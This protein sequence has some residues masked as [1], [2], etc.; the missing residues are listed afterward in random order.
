MPRNAAAPDAGVETALSIPTVQL[1]KHSRNR[2]VS[3]SLSTSTERLHRAHN[4]LVM[5]L[6]SNSIPSDSVRYSWRYRL[7]PNVFRSSFAHATS[8]DV[9]IFTEPRWVFVACAPPP[10]NP[11]PFVVQHEIVHHD[12]YNRKIAKNSPSLV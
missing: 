6:Y 2:Y 10:P 12:T 3:Q 9:R 8:P 1:L 7:V 4:R 5:L 11:L